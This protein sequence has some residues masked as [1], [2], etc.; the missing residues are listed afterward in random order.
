MEC[1]FCP[2]ESIVS[3]GYCRKCLIGRI[4][5]EIEYI[6]KATE[7]RFIKGRLRFGGSKQNAPFPSCIV[8]FK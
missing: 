8:V 7:I 2:S 5:W 6:M 3:D 1:K 4:K